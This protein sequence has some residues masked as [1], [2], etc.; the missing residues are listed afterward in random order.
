MSYCAIFS[1]ARSIGCRL[2]FSTASYVEPN[3]LPRQEAPIVPN[4]INGQAVSSKSTSYLPVHDP[5]TNEVVCYVPES[6]RAELEEAV[7]SSAE[8]FKAWRNFPV[9]KR[10]R[11]FFDL[12]A[13]IRE[14]TEELAALVTAEQGKTLADARGD[15]FRGL[16]VVETACGVAQGGLMGESLSNLASAEM[17]V[18][19]VSYREP[20]GV[21]AGICPFN[22]PA[23]IPLWMFPLSLACGNTMVLKPSERAPG[24]A[25]ALAAMATE[26]GLPPGVLNLVHGSK[27]TVDYLCRR[28]GKHNAHI[29]AVSFVG[30]DVAGRHI[31]AA[32]SEAGKRVQAN[33]GAKNHATV[34]P[35][36]D[37][38]STVA[39]V[40]GAAFGAAG[41][42]CMA[43]SVCILVGQETQS[44]VH[45]L[46][47]AAR[48][49]KVGCGSDPATDIGPLI[50]PQALDR[51]RTLIDAGVEAGATLVLDGRGVEVAP[52][53][54]AG[55]FL[56]PT[57]LSGAGPGN[58]AYDH[59]I[60]GPVLCV[61]GVATLDDAI[62]L[63]N[64]SEKGNGAAIFTASGA[65]ARKFQMEVA[66]GNVGINV[67]IPVP[68]PMFSFSGTRGS[69]Q[70]DLHFYGKEG[71]KFYTRGKVVTSAWPYKRE[72][73][74]LRAS[75]TMPTQSR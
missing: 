26:C 2:R 63:T 1:G 15:V 71:I 25:L 70:G 32:G 11:I 51:A 56:G 45:D 16:E 42:R 38:A 52:R 64:S 65:A 9:Q 5:A 29:Q 62:A 68:L 46:A 44:W 18:D 69:I 61:V 17:G 28:D 31:F 24:A 30:G 66:C 7:W 53:Y 14:R 6:T 58:P 72:E 60:F 39:A 41:Q 73:A 4:Y 21:T 57:V 13:M 67:P 20:L 43:L 54:E 50:S 22:F 36:A 47:Q 10:Q 48:L 23:M 34:L 74:S 33:L 40:V 59:E 55:N 19:A 49:L 75:V 8:A 37:K 35:D 12:Q 27:G 3:H